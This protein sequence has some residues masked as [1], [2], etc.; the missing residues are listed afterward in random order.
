M[1]TD[2][3]DALSRGEGIYLDLLG[4]EGVK[5]G[6]PP[7]DH[8]LLGISIDA[9]AARVSSAM[10]KRLAVL[11]RAKQTADSAVVD[12]LIQEVSA[13][14]S[15]LLGGEQRSDHVPSHN[16]SRSANKGRVADNTRQ[17]IRRDRPLDSGTA[18]P[19]TSQ[20]PSEPYCPPLFNVKTTQAPP[21]QRPL[22]MIYQSPARHRDIHKIRSLAV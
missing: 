16:P 13:A 8:D 7:S 6:T 14:A 15:R 19:K 11:H 2:E 10:Q 1:S 21:Y 20:P 22:K 5:A 4:I 17:E 9:S 12:R 3:S 18:V